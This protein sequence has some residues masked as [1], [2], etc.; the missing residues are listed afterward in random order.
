MA[1]IKYQSR[2]GISEVEMRDFIGVKYNRWQNGAVVDIPDDEQSTVRLP[3]GDTKQVKTV[4]Y[5]LGMGPDFVDATTGKNPNYICAKCG[6]E[7]LDDGYLDMMTLETHP[8]RDADGKRLCIVDYL[9]A[10]PQSLNQHV[11][12]GLP[13][14]MEDQIRANVE[15]TSGAKPV[16]RSQP[17]PPIQPNSPAPGVAVPGVIQP[18]PSEVN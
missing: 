9:S 15:K 13:K 7:T 4:D 2:A 16:V 1:G 11:R 8:Y 17:A 10:N 14:D 18:V 5:V 6:K 3:N 12:L